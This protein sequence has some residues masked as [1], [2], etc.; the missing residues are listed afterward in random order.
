MAL[1]ALLLLSGLTAAR[2]AEFLEP[3]KAFQLSARSP[4]GAQVE[5]RALP[6]L[7]EA[8]GEFQLHFPKRFTA[9]LQ[10]LR[11]LPYRAYFAVL[12]RV[13]GL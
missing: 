9:W 4:D 7:Y 10:L 13:T 1:P 11:V 3:D 6:S 5:V 12:R 2:A 8:R